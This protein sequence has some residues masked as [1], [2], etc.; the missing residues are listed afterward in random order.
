M[1]FAVRIPMT[2]FKCL[3]LLSIYCVLSAFLYYSS[4][5]FYQFSLYNTTFYLLSHI[6]ILVGNLSVASNFLKC[7]IFIRR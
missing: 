2:F 1:L 5:S 4:H 3:H 6:H 7:C